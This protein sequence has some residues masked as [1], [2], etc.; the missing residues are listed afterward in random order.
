MFEI[1]T[2]GGEMLKTYITELEV[3]ETNGNDLIAK[4]KAFDGESYEIE[5]NTIV[6]GDD[7]REIAKILDNLYEAK[8]EV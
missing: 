5:C 2:Q 3:C 1:R 7:L 8:G 6:T 4:I